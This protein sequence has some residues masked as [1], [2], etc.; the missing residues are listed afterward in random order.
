[1]SVDKSLHIYII[2]RVTFQW[3]FYP[4]A[5][6]PGVQKIETFTSGNSG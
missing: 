4:S 1:M 2:L 3:L 5:G 6:S